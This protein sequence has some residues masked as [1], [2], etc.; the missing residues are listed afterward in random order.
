[1]AEQTLIP[2]PLSRVDLAAFDPDDT[3]GAG[4]VIRR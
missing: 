4:L 1:M 2:A 3:N